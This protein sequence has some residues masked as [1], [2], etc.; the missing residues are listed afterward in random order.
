MRI[1]ERQTLRF[2][3]MIGITSGPEPE[4]IIADL[5]RV[6]V[7]RMSPYPYHTAPALGLDLDWVP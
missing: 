1:T 3:K 6:Q 2:L 5:P 4:H 7:E